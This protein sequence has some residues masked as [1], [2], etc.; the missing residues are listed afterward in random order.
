[1]KVRGR[2]YKW[3]LRES[4]TIEGE[5]YTCREG[6]KQEGRLLLYKG[7]ERGNSE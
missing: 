6:G 1:M 7:G 3:I 5:F 2:K 4:K